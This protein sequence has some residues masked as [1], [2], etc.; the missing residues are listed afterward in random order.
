MSNEDYGG[1]V[2]DTGGETNLEEAGGEDQQD[3]S[4]RGVES[5]GGGA[6]GNG[7]GH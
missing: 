4:R 1:N 2:S 3:V 5:R 6:E 7:R